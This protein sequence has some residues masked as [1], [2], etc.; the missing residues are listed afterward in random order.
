MPTEAQ[1][2]EPQK[3]KGWWR[4]ALALREHTTNKHL[5]GEICAIT[6]TKHRTFT[7]ERP[8]T[9]L[10]KSRNLAVLTEDYRSVQK[11]E[12]KKLGILKCR[13]GD[14]KKKRRELL[15]SWW[16]QAGTQRPMSNSAVGA[17]LVLA[18][19]LASRLNLWREKS[20]ICPRMNTVS[21]TKLACTLSSSS[22]K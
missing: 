15:P 17:R 20:R 5:S 19:L 9:R 4:T 18:V 13:S 21:G 7:G 1:L 3:K 11:R 22:S 12:K 10:L 6:K 16:S 2:V 14:S 8:A